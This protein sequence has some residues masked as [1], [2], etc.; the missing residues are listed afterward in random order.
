MLYTIGHLMGLL[1]PLCI[2]IAGFIT[3]LQAAD[4]YNE[5]Q[6]DVNGTEAGSDR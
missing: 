3:L 6:E 1:F 5:W 2:G 4:Y